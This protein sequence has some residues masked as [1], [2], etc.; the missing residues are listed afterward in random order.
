LEPAPT[1]LIAQVATSDT[2]STTF[3]QDFAAAHDALPSWA[4]V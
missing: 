3:P 2:P 1:I 4:V